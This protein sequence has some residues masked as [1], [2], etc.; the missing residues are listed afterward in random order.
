[1]FLSQV[2]VSQKITQFSSM[3]CDNTGSKRHQI[4]I[5]VTSFIF[6][7]RLRVS[8]DL[9]GLHKSA[10]LRCNYLKRFM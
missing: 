2:A 3:I 10:F 8:R 5:F 4:R 9:L 7:L 6:R 1:M